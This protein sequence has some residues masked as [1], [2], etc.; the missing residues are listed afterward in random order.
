[1]MMIHFRP[2]LSARTPV[3]GL[4]TSAKKLVLAVIILLSKAVS[5]RDKSEPMEIRVD[6][7]TPVLHSRQ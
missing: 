6:D 5:G 1:M 3:T 2:S 4:A 7:M